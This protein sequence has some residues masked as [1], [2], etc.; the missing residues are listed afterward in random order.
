MSLHPPEPDD[1]KE[2]LS[3]AARMRE[4]ADDPHHVA[5]WLDYYHRRCHG[6]E[7]LL[8]ATDRYLRFGLPEHELAEMRLLV[9]RLRASDW[10]ADYRG[11][12]ESPLPL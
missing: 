4:E 2:A 12:T 5:K 6:L 1:L 9:E 10:N 8:H 3:A 7:D 11:T